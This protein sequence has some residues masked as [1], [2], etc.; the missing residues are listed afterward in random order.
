[1]KRVILVLVLIL[2]FTTYALPG[3]GEVTSAVTGRPLAGRETVRTQSAAA[4][5][6]SNPLS[7][8]EGVPVDGDLALYRPATDMGLCL[9]SF[10][11]PTEWTE[12]VE[13]TCRRLPRERY[14]VS[15]NLPGH[16]DP[17]E[18]ILTFLLCEHGK[19]D[20]TKMPTREIASLR[21][22]TGRT[23]D[24]IAF[25]PDSG[26]DDEQLRSMREAIPEILDSVAFEEGVEV[27]LTANQAT[28]VL[29]DALAKAYILTYGSLSEP[30]EGDN[31]F[32][33]V[34]WELLTSPRVLSEDESYYVY[35]GVT[36]FRVDK[37]TGDIYKHIKGSSPVTVSFDPEAEDALTFRQQP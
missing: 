1:M 12:T 11:C 6:T 13:V 23:L 27:L 25:W 20:V 18:R 15:L 24:L 8:V 26:D 19:T 7:S 28:E 2:V 33:R 21:D 36:P 4:P 34:F 3:S 17:E 35:S 9:F 31:T 29:H 10:R 32:R 5:A 37:R 30:D 14:S 22:N 16:P